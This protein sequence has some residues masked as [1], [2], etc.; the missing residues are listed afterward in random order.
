MVSYVPQ[1]SATHVT[2]V[3][4]SGTIRLKGVD[5]DRPILLSQQQQ[6]DALEQRRE[7]A[8]VSYTLYYILGGVGAVV[9]L[10]LLLRPK[11]LN[12]TSTVS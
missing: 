7:T 3:D 6:L 8:P 12:P 2:L 9:L 10:A 4:D 5:F 1:L 11:K